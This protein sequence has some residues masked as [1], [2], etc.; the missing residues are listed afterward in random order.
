MAVVGTIHGTW[1]QLDLHDRCLVKYLLLTKSVVHHLQ[2]MTN[3]LFLTFYYA[4]LFP[5][6]F[7]LAAATLAVHYW[8]DKYCLLRNWA[9]APKLGGAIADM[10][11]VYFFSTAVAVYAVVSSYNLASFPYDNACGTF[12]S[13]CTARWNVMAMATHLSSS[14]RVHLQR[15][16]RSCHH[17]TWEPSTPLAG[18]AFL[19]LWRYLKGITIFSFVTKT[20]CAIT[21]PPSPQSHRT[22][23]LVENG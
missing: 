3:V 8:T 4:F 2:D 14:C 19:S 9:H 21:R 11:R 7:F 12:F 22:N 16:I 20:C 17:S 23:L 10:S 15:T 18:M 5:A 6:G 1:L 13:P